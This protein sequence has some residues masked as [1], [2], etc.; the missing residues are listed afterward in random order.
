MERRRS[1]FSRGSGDGGWEGAGEG[2]GGKVAWVVR[3]GEKVG[4]AA[5][6][7]GGAVPWVVIAGV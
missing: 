4:L 5:V 6:V 7:V 2:G 3:V 1:R